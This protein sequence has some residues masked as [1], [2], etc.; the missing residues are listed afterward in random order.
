MDN[1]VVIDLEMTGLNAKRDMILETGAVRVRNGRAAETC[2]ALLCTGRKLSEDVI[3]LTG[4][5]EKMAAAGRQ[6]EEAMAEFFAFLGDDVLVGQNIIFDYSFLKQWAVNH[7][8]SFERRAVDTLKLS[9]QFLPKEQKKELESLCTHFGIVRRNAHRA[10]DDAWETWQIME[11]LKAKFG[12][13]NPSAFEPKPLQYKA[14]KVTP[15]TEHQKENLRQ[16]AA[17]HGLEVPP[18]LD[19]LTRNEVSRLTDLWIAGYGRMPKQNR[20]RAE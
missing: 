11:I 2:T 10:L 8:F 3:Q 9:R 7:N 17:Y 6:P 1:Y 12:A 4:I 18:D 20:G 15:A 16:F 14:K 5:T 19:Q 13:E